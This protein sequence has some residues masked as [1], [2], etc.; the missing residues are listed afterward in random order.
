MGASATVE[1]AEGGADPELSPPQGSGEQRCRQAPP[2]RN[3]RAPAGCAEGQ[4]TWRGS[5]APSLATPAGP[6]PSTWCEG[7]GAGGACVAWRVRPW[8]PPLHVRGAAGCTRFSAR[9]HVHKAAHLHTHV[10]T[11]ARLP[12]VHARTRCG[13]HPPP[14]ARPRPCVHIARALWSPQWAHAGRTGARVL[15]GRPG[16]GNSGWGN[17][18]GGATRCPGILR[19][20]PRSLCGL[21]SICVCTCVSV[22]MTAC[23]CEHSGVCLFHS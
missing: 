20:Q 11:R 7:L 21:S 23:S 10:H 13:A 5:S 19:S 2:I 6:F 12:R 15:A 16:S 9:A 1:G 17:R 22:L 18:A 4:G 14:P 8:S 3:L